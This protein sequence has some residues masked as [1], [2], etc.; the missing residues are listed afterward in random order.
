MLG[1]IIRGP[2]LALVPPRAA[3]IE[4]WCRWVA[5]SEVTRYLK[6]FV[7][8]PKGEADWLERTAY[9]RDTVLWGILVGN[10]LIGSSG[11]SAIDWRHRHAASGTVIK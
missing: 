3:F 4:A 5:D 8:T 11:L 6:R 2:R 1:P 7:P 9:S 10:Q